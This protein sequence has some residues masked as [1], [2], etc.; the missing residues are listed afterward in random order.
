MQ[1]TK[2]N[3]K[4]G[5]DIPKKKKKNQCKVVATNSRRQKR[6][7]GMNELIITTKIH[8]RKPR[9]KPIREE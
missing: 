6:K 3:N 8:Q 4:K 1:W 5:A 9:L 2:T 7:Y